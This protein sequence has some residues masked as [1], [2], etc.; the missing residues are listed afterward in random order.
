[1]TGGLSALLLAAFYCVMDVWKHRTWAT[2]FIWVGGSAITL[3][4]ING[5]VGFKALA[6]RL[7]GGDV[8][9]FANVHFAPAAGDFLACAVG[10][11]LAVA[12]AAFLYRR[13][14]FLRV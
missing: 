6:Q 4:F 12:L 11:M 1:V 9:R 10:L 2:V 13:E 5:I 8:G 14:I 3:Y 7:V